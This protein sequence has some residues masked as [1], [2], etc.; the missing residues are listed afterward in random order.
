MTDDRRY[1]A[2]IGL[3]ADFKH[4]PFIKCP[5]SWQ[6]FEF[7]YYDKEDEDSIQDCKCIASGWAQTTKQAYDCAITA[8]NNIV[9]NK[10]GKD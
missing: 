1:E 8:F 3:T 5:Y 6:L 4:T 2:K 10:D 7:I 9:C